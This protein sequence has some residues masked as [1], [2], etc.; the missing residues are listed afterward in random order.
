MFEFALKI[1]CWLKSKDGSMQEHL[2]MVYMIAV[3]DSIGA[4]C[5]M[6]I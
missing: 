5:A 1:E 4:K 3:K 6:W 2:E